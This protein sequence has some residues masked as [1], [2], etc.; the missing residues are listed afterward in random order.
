MVISKQR[1]W[2]AGGGDE[3][4]MFTSGKFRQRAKWAGMNIVKVD[5]QMMEKN[6][7]PFGEIDDANQCPKANANTCQS[8]KKFKRD[9]SLPRPEIRLRAVLGDEVGPANISAFRGRWRNPS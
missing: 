3:D 7:P 9:N 4:G 6:I 1:Y 2:A 8:M 5:K